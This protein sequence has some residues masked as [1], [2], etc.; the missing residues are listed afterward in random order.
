MPIVV[1]HEP[2]PALVG[3]AA[4]AAGYGKRQNELQ[5]QAIQEASRSA[6]RN[7]R[8][9]GMQLDEQHR[10][11]SLGMDAYQASAQRDFAA[12]KQEDEQEFN[13]GG[14][15]A[16]QDFRKQLA[17]Q[18]ME[19]EKE[20]FDYQWTAKQKAEMGRLNNYEQSI[21]SSP[22]LDAR[23]KEM[24]LL[25]LEGQRAGF[26]PMAIP[27]GPKP[28]R[29]QEMFESGQVEWVQDPQTGARFIASFDRSGA[30]KFTEVN[31]QTAEELAA[32]REKR[33]LEM[34]GLRIKAWSD[35][36]KALEK[37]D[38]E[39]G[40]TLQPGDLEIEE[41]IRK[42]N[43]LAAGMGQVVNNAAAPGSEQPQPKAVL[44]VD[45][46]QQSPPQQAP[47]PQQPAP[48]MRATAPAEQQQIVGLLK[49]IKQRYPDISK[50]PLE[51]RQQ[52]RGLMQHLELYEQAGAQ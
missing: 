16:Q 44:S 7:A 46:P 49:G 36:K 14:Q 1:A 34:Q 25:E 11:R 30:P 38:V 15:Y 48:G 4:M 35:A 10:A 51:V 39:S 20:L 28:Q 12:R 9:L 42:A 23:D 8:L 50:A 40:V 33:S 21:R 24:M 13:Q 17:D 29:I 41:H 22:Q 26:R 6:D 19:Q 45:L 2:N 37:V 47:P 43:K 31:Q 5:D 18:R 52:V 3:A 32:A 27:K